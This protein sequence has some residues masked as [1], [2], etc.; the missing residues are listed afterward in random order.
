MRFTFAA[1]WRSSSYCE[2]QCTY[3]GLRRDRS[4]LPRYRLTEAEILESARLAVRLGYGTVVLQS[5]EDDGQTV[6][7]LAGLIRTLRTTTTLAVTLSLGER[8]DEEVLRAFRDAGADRYLLRF[9][10]SDQ[11]LYRRIHPD[12]PGRKSDRVGLLR[13]LRGWGYEI[14]SGVMVGIPGQT[15]D[16]LADDVELIRSLD[17]DMIGIG[18]F[19]AHPDTPLGAHAASA[20]SRQAP[21]TEQ[22][23]LKMVA[24]ARLVCPRA[25]I[26]STTA[27]ATVD[28]AEGREA[29]LLRG[30]NIWMPNLTPVQYRESYE[31]TREGVRP[32]RRPALRPVCGCA[33]PEPGSSHRRRSGGFAGTTSPA[34]KSRMNTP[35]S[36]ALS[37]GAVDF[38]DDGNLEHLLGRLEPASSEVR[39]IIAKS[40]ARESLEV[41]ETAV[42]L[43]TRQP[44]LVEEIFEAARRLKREVYGNRIV[45]FAPLYVG[46][47][48]INDCVYCGFRRSSA[49]AIRRDLSGADLEREVLSLERVGHKRLI[50]VFGEHP[51][52]DAPTIAEAV[53]VVYAVKEGNGEI[54]RVNVNAAPLDHE[55]FRTVKEAGIGTYQIFHETYHHAT[56]ARVHPPGTRKAD[57]L[58][59]LDGPSRAMLA[60]CDDVGIGALFGLA[61]WRFEVLGLVAH[62]RHLQRRFGVGP[63]TISFPRMRP[64]AG[65][66]YVPEHPVS[67]HEML[68]VVAAL[69]LAAPYTGLICTARETASVRREALRLGVSQID[70]GSRIDLGGYSGDDAHTAERSQFLLGDTRSLSDVTLELLEDGHVPSYC[71]ACY[72][73]GRTGEHFM[74]AR[75]SR[76]HSR[77]LHPQR[78]LHPPGVPR[79]LRE[80]RAQGRGTGRGC[81]RACADAGG[82]APSPPRRLSEEDSRSGRPRHPVLAMST[83]LEE[84]LLGERAVPAGVLHG[85][86]TERAIE[87]FPLALRPVQPGLIHA[88][89][90]VKLACACA[91]HELG[92]WDAPTYAAIERACREMMEGQLDEHIVVDALQGGAG[93]SMNMNVNE[94]LTN[95]ALILLERPIGE[96]GTLSPLE[97]LNLHQSTNDT[98]PTAL[99]VAALRECQALER[100]VLLLQE[101][102]QAK[103]RELAGVRK[104][105]RTEMQDA[106]P[107]TLGQE[108]GAYAEAFARESLAGLQVRGA[109]PGR[110]PR[111]H[112]DRDRARRPALVCLPGGGA[113]PPG[114]GLAD[115]PRRQSHRGDAERR[116]VRRGQR[117]LEGLCGEPAEGGVRPS[118][119]IERP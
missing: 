2:R 8:P 82:P 39:D 42:L 15:I 112:R 71:T 109:P 9:E 13:R 86:H 83:R 85:I 60:G 32:R 101:A 58:F 37:D 16:S 119:S 18:P 49:A 21:A 44:E 100:E 56:Y 81:A 77:V 1:S 72:R 14:G 29:A 17:L 4:Q 94:V 84:D 113:P 92:R 62:A 41:A 105:G 115:R 47:Q 19:V 40:L 68:R 28:P 93:T 52:W 66:D 91:N 117:H 78:A 104:M 53:R 96:Y 25:N 57:Y 99:R 64:A 6:E 23:T 103:E 31:I 5:G 114:H 11:R 30:A 12:R 24:L 88:Y 116:R 43:R 98:F 95:R 87:N 61:D 80:P 35:Q 74:A 70:G 10:T 69:R 90:A 118:R 59:R 51:R 102:F 20:G 79:R 106:V 22:M 34:G 111:G 38:I 67:D 76:L 27:L 54:R 108:M 33:N 89:G 50:L 36:R 26:P 45:L 63:H 46:N 3:C 65:V 75:H 107:I 97:D 7:W 48:C 55:G 73:M 110:Q